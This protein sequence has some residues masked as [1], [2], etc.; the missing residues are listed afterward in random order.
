MSN[1]SV[2]H[3]APEASAPKVERIARV[4]APV[5]GDYWRATREFKFFKPSDY[6]KGEQD[7]VYT[8]PKGLVLMIADVRQ[9]AGSDHTV[10]LQRHPSHRE[11]TVRIL[12][13]DFLDAFEHAPDGA[14]VRE[15]ELQALQNK[16]AS[17]QLEIARAADDPDYMNAQITAA[18]P[19]DTSTKST[20]GLPALPGD[21]PPV[22]VL[23]AQ[24]PTL[25]Q[26]LRAGTS[27][28]M[29]QAL[30]VVRGA[31]QRA[32]LQAEWFGRR[33]EEITST[34]NKMVPYLM[35]RASVALARNRSSVDRAEKLM[36][37]V[38]TLKLF[39]G[40]E[41]RCT[42]IVDGQPA[43]ADAP[44]KLFQRKLYID[45]EMAYVTAYIGG[46]DC[47]NYE[48]FVSELASNARLQELLI[49]AQRGVALVAL[50]RQ[51]VHRGNSLQTAL[52][53]LRI[54]EA[55]RAG[56]LLVRDGQSFYSVDTPVPSHETCSMLFPETDVD[57]NVFR[58]TNGDFVTVE[59]LRWT[60]GLSKLEALAVHYRRFAVV[61]AGLIA[62]ETFWKGVDYLDLFRG[63]GNQRIFEMIRDASGEMALSQELI[64]ISE[65][66]ER[67]NGEMRV[68]SRI[69]MDL[70]RH[71]SNWSTP[72]A[73]TTRYSAADRCDITVPLA[74]PLVRWLDAR[75]EG[76]PGSLYVTAP[77]KANADDKHR[78]LRVYLVRDGKSAH[79]HFSWIAIDHV[80]ADQLDA[81]MAARENRK[82]FKD[83]MALFRKARDL[84][85]Q[86]ELEMHPSVQRLAGEIS[87]AGLADTAQAEAIARKTVM[88]FVAD[89]K[90]T[91][92]TLTAVLQ[93]PSM[94][95]E[96]RA[97]A[98]R[99]TH[100]G[101]I[102]L[103]QLE[104]VAAAEGLVP[105]RFFAESSGRL[106]LY[107]EDP[108]PDHRCARQTEV[109][110]HVVTPGARKLRLSNPT[111]ETLWKSDLTG[112]VLHEWPAA[113]AWT[114][115]A[116]SVLTK[117]R[118]ADVIDDVMARFNTHWPLLFGALDDAHQEAVLLHFKTTFREINR[119]SRYVTT[120]DIV[121]PIGLTGTDHSTV[122][123]LG[124]RA[125]ALT[126]SRSLS[127]RRQEEFAS[128]Y[129][130][131]YEKPEAA[132]RRLEQAKSWS[133]E[134]YRLVACKASDWVVGRGL[135][136]PA[137]VVR[138]AD[139]HT[140]LESGRMFGKRVSDLAGVG[141]WIKRVATAAPGN[142]VLGGM[143][144]GYTISELLLPDAL[145]AH[146]V[147]DNPLI[148]AITA[149]GGPL[150]AVAAAD[151]G[152]GPVEA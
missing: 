41:V 94:W 109:L 103:A 110:R 111:L 90:I 115:T 12:V 13:Q 34:A 142:H 62:T 11:G 9:N 100:A 14:Q 143:G 125:S 121:V 40:D 68:G 55:N 105:L 20:T 17:I 120:P 15:R 32:T 144:I 24:A 141:T 152:H 117:R 130:G 38:S 29:N 134:Q 101:R 81:L 149:L 71:V 145:N 93:V 61:L 127:A 69:L 140:Y 133:P 47:R 37:S 108:R 44:I 89:R 53:A 25:N 4:D 54:E 70:D 139:V 2:T 52:E 92:S 51:Y 49:P 79:E 39:S 114:Q 95:D 132:Y 128:I 85:I 148:A 107:T 21:L 99:M 123:V 3:A 122:M 150:A 33:A 91:S 75:V 147:A 78:E 84:S 5:P 146:L 65:Y 30:D 50:S 18:L 98:F 28:L 136:D 76:E 129:T 80:D 26:A 36:E 77:F 45:E 56:F 63:D 27:G 119:R 126:L 82:G 96:V 16:I 73:F 135:I 88:A 151:E 46:V 97:L 86:N 113:A 66:L 8:A 124:L 57:G 137:S 22:D 19:Q 74:T 83:F 102:D 118:K 116:P 67:A 131:I 104:A 1:V 7:H 112:A 138:S 35:E 106:L 48:V 31:Q 23:N 59:D 6:R 10:I 43:P 72:K 64:G 58:A 87:D 42:R 60:D